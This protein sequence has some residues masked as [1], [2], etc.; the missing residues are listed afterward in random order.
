[1][2]PKW[3]WPETVVDVRCTRRVQRSAPSAW[4]RGECERTKLSSDRGASL[5]P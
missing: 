4:S 5:P 1:M 3:R 2:L